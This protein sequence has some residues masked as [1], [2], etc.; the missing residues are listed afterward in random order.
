MSYGRENIIIA[1]LLVVHMNTNNNRNIRGKTMEKKT[2]NDI[3]EILQEIRDPETINEQ[4]VP[5]NVRGVYYTYVD[6]V[7]GLEDLNHD[8]D[9]VLKKLEKEAK[10]NLD[11][12]QKHLDKKYN[13]KWD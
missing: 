11:K 12:L 9:P 1:L 7:Y 2:I 4:E 8:N 10:K 3:T 5:D 13:K 6:A